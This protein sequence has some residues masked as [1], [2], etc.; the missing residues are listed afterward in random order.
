MI[1]TIMT[2]T[3]TIA[4]GSKDSNRL[5]APKIKETRLAKKPT[6]KAITVSSVSCCCYYYC[7][8]CCCCCCCCYYYCC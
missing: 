5:R 2:I 8:C 1:T 3:T 6:K 4:V 7:G